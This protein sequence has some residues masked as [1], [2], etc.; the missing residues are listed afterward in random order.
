M[1]ADVNCVCN[2]CGSAHSSGCVVNG[3]FAREAFEYY[4]HIVMF[5]FPVATW[6]WRNMSISDNCVW[7]ETRR[8]S[9]E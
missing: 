8:S 2:V 9:S 3:S 1:H 7:M 4:K 5:L 6:R